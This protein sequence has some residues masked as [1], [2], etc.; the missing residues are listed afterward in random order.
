MNLVALEP[1]FGSQLQ[2]VVG[3][4]ASRD[5]VWSD[6]FHY[7]RFYCQAKVRK[8]HIKVGFIFQFGLHCLQGKILDGRNRLRG[9][10]AGI[11][12]PS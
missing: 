7:R 8:S 10:Q 2:D 3:L 4:T 11:S 12:H 6:N 9:N 5:C 1:V